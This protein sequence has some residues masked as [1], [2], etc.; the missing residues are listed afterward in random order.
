MKIFL[1]ILA[2]LV[3]T[4]LLSGFAP[5]AHAQPV[6]RIPVTVERLSD[7]WFNIRVGGRLDA[8]MRVQVRRA[9][10]AQPLP[11]VFVEFFPNG[12]ICMPLSNCVEPPI[13]L[14]GGFGPEL[15]GYAIVQTDAQGVADAPPFT[16][17]SVRGSY[18][19]AGWVWPGH[20][21]EGH[22]SVPGF[23]G[24]T[25]TQY[26]AVDVPADDNIALVLLGLMLAGAGGCVL[27]RAVRTTG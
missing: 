17:G 12:I 20:N 19:L 8:P 7:P 11:G 4:L 9:S 13:E 5:H 14:Y 1:Q 26:P 16:A 18:Q 22:S 24:V 15:R 2:C 6:P 21:P 25:I 10:D 23:A 3:L 27:S